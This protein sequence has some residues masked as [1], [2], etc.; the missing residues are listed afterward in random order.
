MLLRR[1]ILRFSAVLLLIASLAALLV[2][3]SHITKSTPEK[4]ASSFYKAIE[5]RDERALLDTLSSEPLDAPWLHVTLSPDINMEIEASLREDSTARVKNS[6]ERYVSR[7]PGVL[8]VSFIPERKSIAMWTENTSWAGVL[9]I[10]VNR[11]ADTL[12]LLQLLENRPELKRSTGSSS[13]SISIPLERN[14]RHFLALTPGRLRF[15]KITYG[16]VIEG[17]LAL[18]SVARGMAEKIDEKGNIVPVNL[19]EFERIGSIPS[20]FLMRKMK[21]KWKIISFPRL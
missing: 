11:P 8:S 14:V 5:K 9:R 17:N 10:T 4:T 12:V 21:N 3:I 19:K 20:A 2:I 1:K 15:R 7:I 13:A 16:K 18:L 6:L